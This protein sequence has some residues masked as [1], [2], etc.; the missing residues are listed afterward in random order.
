M[1]T[2][3]MEQLHDPG[4]AW[5]PYQPS[6]SH[7]WNLRQAAHLYRR[8]GFSA[9]WQQLQQALADAPQQTV[10]QLLH[11]TGEVS[12]FNQIYD[13]YESSATDSES[14]DTLRAWWLRRMLLTPHP[15]LE[16]MTLFWHN[17][18]AV[19]NVQVKSAQMMMQYIRQLRSHALGNFASLLESILHEPAILT[20]LG[21]EANRRAQP[22]E[23]FARVLLE[24]YCLGP[25]NCT[26][27]DIRDTARAF[28]GWF[29]YRNRLRYIQHEHDEGEKE[30]LGEKGNFGSKDVIRILLEQPAMHRL[31][32][33]KLYRWFISET[34]EPSN[35]LIDPLAESFAQDFDLAKLMSTILQSNLFFSPQAYR[36]KIKSP[37]EYAVGIVQSMEANVSASELGNDVAALG[38]NLYNPPTSKGWPGGH[39]W[40]DNAT[41]IGRSNLAYNLLNKN[42][43]YGEN[44]DPKAIAK[45]HGFTTPEMKKN[46]LLDLFVQ[47]DIQTE[48]GENIF[49]KL[50][51]NKRQ[52]Q[53]LRQIAHQ[54]VTL[55]E[56]HL[57]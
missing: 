33:R 30:I 40:I 49:S 15:L 36:Q 48:S 6:A 16:K 34:D 20:G 27:K 18:F 25:G 9:N 1:P 12:E 26:E 37:V 29:V 53:S 32:I 17:H 55:P 45:K 10:E 39:R 8:A 23:D 2:K 51:D 7:P 24:T 13:E 5:S 44:I 41:M 46:F 47:R 56:F 19:S 52:S 14:T 11:P 50:S 22:C 31:L 28:T 42:G 38:Q 54:I 3:K 57:A 21:A 43:T 35:A 4:W